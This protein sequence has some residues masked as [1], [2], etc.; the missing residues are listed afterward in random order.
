MTR[1]YVLMEVEQSKVQKVLNSL[2]KF[3][4]V[5]EF[6]AI[7]GNFDVI[8]IVE[9]LDQNDVGMICAKEL[10]KL[11]GVRRTVTYTAVSF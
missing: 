9:G 6:D 4:S 8:A 5:K 7:V 10:A 3:D 1:A 11:E 2:T